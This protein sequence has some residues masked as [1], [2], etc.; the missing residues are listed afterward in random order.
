M[1]RRCE[2][3]PPTPPRDPGP[4]PFCQ[5]CG[6]SAIVVAEDDSDCEPK[7]GSSVEVVSADEVENMA[8]LIPTKAPIF[9]CIGGYGLGT[10]VSVSAPPGGGK[11]TEALR[12]AVAQNARVLHL[13]YGEC[14]PEQAKAA[15][16]DAGATAKWFRDKKH[17]IAMA[18]DWR[19][20]ADYMKRACASRKKP[21]FVIWDST[22]MWVPNQSD[23][24]DFIRVNVDMADE[25]QVVVFCITHWSQQGRGKGTLTIPH[26]GA[27]WMRIKTTTFEVLKARPPWSGKQGVYPRPR[28][29]PGQTWPGQEI[30]VEQ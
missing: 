12:V 19:D 30:K 20:A 8:P 26:G 5:W 4:G 16:K 18:E 29:K 17:Q 22:S 13:I 3:C 28:L 7:R 21:E 25:F 10:V 14:S 23:E 11:T 1:R 24:N 15:A 9:D 2:S 27:L 6:S